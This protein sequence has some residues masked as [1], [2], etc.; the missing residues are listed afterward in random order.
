MVVRMS[1]SPCYLNLNNWRILGGMYVVWADK[2]KI[3]PKLKEFMF[4]YLYDECWVSHK[5]LY[6]FMSKLNSRKVVLDFLGSCTGQK[7]RDCTVGGNQ[8]GDIDIKL[9]NGWFKI[10]AQLN[11][12]DKEN[13]IQVEVGIGLQAIICIFLQ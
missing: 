2:N 8:S 12:L 13:F 5:R 9:T 4:L 11:A 1:L 3:E 6:Y 10:L 7:H